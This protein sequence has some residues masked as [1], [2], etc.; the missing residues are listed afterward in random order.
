[1]PWY[2][3]ALPK[4][5]S[6]ME[7]RYV[8]VHSG[9]AVCY[10]Q[11]RDVGPFEEDDID[12]VLGTAPNPRN[13]NQLRAGLD[14]SPA[15][16][17]CLGVEDVS[18]T[19]WR[20]VPESAVT[21]EQSNSTGEYRLELP[22][23]NTLGMPFEVTW[24]APFPRQNTRSWI[25]V[26]EPT[27]PDQRPIDWERIE[28]YTI[29]GTYTVSVSRAGTYEVRLFDGATYDRVYTE[30]FVIGAAKEN[31]TY[32]VSLDQ[33]PPAGGTARAT[34][35]TPSPQP[36]RRSWVGLYRPEDAHTDPIDW[37]RIP[38]NVTTGLYEVRIPGTG[39]YEIRLF[40]GATYDTVATRQFKAT[41]DAPIPREYVLEMPDK[42]QP[43]VEVAAT[44]YTP[45]TG[46]EARSWI[47]VYVENARSQDPLF[48]E[49]IPE[50]ADRGT[51]LFSLDT[52]GTYELRLFQGA[53]YDSAAV[54]PFT[55][56]TADMDT[57][58]NSVEDSTSDLDAP[59]VDDPNSETIVVETEETGTDSSEETG[60]S[61]D[62]TTDNTDIDSNY[63][64]EDQSE[65]TTRPSTD[66]GDE[67]TDNVR[68]HHRHSG[69]WR[70]KRTY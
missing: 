18:R 31:G 17:D 15:M 20:F 61:T 26:Y 57:V 67:V 2:D 44:W 51:Y 4:K 28:N 33:V 27:D 68:R 22:S 39:A 66:T 35:T 14:I 52:P 54:L 10:G 63:S 53:T 12:Y 50:T 56:A 13:Q 21:T 34:W 19:R 49:R 41:G 38:D 40:R 58:D 65:T 16:R 25:G 3:A 29:S 46:H 59:Y 8:A 69:Y 48:W 30:S 62:Q 5:A 45:T 7:G 42:V 55:V 70:H 64:D 43:G 47:G 6:Q 32:S 37:E 23:A 24:Y 60:Q 11:V 9:T 1:M 36:A